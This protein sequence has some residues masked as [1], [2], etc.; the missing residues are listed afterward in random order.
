MHRTRRWGGLQIGL[1]DG[2]EL[3]GK[4]HPAGSL[5]EC[6]AGEL[7][8]LGDIGNLRHACCQ[9]LGAVRL[10]TAGEL[11]V[12]VQRLRIGRLGD[13]HRPGYLVKPTQV[14]LQ[15][16]ECVRHWAE[17]GG[18]GHRIARR[19]VDLAYALLDDAL[20]R[21]LTSL[22]VGALFP[23]SLHQSCGVAPAGSIDDQI[24]FERSRIDF[25]RSER[26]R[27]VTAAAGLVSKVLQPP[28]QAGLFECGLLLCG[29]GRLQV[30]LLPN[31]FHLGAE[32]SNTFGDLHRPTDRGRA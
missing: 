1:V 3:F 32:L 15:L 25:Q 29:T 18:I 24:S 10:E 17:G 22:Q 19:W 8:S 12:I 23:G 20:Q 30:D 26:S 28:C 14:V 21:G 2:N 31:T 27:H 9:C 5:I 6:I 7:I 13:G 11:V 16:I 4:H